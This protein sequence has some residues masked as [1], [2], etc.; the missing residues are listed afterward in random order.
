MYDAL[1]AS[2]NRRPD[3]LETF[4]LRPLPSAL[5]AIKATIFGKKSAPPT[6]FDLSSTKIFKPTIGLQAWFNQKPANQLVPIY[7]FFNRI[8][9][10][11][12]E[13]YSVKVTFARDYLGGQ[14][15]YDGH[16]GTDF[17]TP[18]G[19]KII[20]GAPGIVLRVK[21][22][23]DRGGLK[24][25]IDHG[26]GLFTTSNHLARAL[27]RPGDCVQRGDVIGLSGASG[28]EFLMLFPWVAPHLH[29]N[30]WLN[31]TPV[32]PFATPN[33][34]SL[35]MNRNNPTPHV[36]SSSA[37]FEPTQWSHDL[38][39]Q[40]ISACKDDQLRRAMAQ[41]S[42]LSE[43]AAEVMIQRNYRAVLF[44]AFPPLYTTTYEREP[45]LDLPFSPEDYRGASLWGAPLSSIEKQ[46]DSGGSSGP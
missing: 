19:T 34:T 9:Q 11:N 12:N 42:S 21:N 29:Y 45:T 5:R 31:G 14:H 46:G 15:T 38:I 23:L 4:G 39:T 36:G 37:P 40:A 33:E 25:C 20:T 27:V 35:W 2:L 32:D 16:L 3:I 43:R 44:S 17:V 6:Q 18:V 1:M 28:V 30:V 41:I 10:P 22:D 7:N 13:A 24:V 26:R 8:P